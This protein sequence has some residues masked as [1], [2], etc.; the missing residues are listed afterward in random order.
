[1]T[2]RVIHITSHMGGGVGRVLKH[3]CVASRESADV[4][5]EIAC[6]DYAND[7]A[8]QWAHDTEHEVWGDATK[9][10]ARLRERIADSDIVH[11]HWWNS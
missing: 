2:I 4:C 7:N 6:L 3:F 1:M 11:V 9:D 10:K 5:H 8:L